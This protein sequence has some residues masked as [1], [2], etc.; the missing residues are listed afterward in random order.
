[1]RFSTE[2][3]LVGAVC[4]SSST[5][6]LCARRRRH[7]VYVLVV[8]DTMSMCSSTSNTYVRVTCKVGT[9]E[10]KLQHVKEENR[11]LRTRLEAMNSKYEKLQSHLQEISDAEKVC[12]KVNQSGSASYLDTHQRKRPEFS[13]AQKPSQIFVRTHPNDNSLTVKDGYQWKKYGQK[14]TKDNASPRA[15]FKCSMAP[16]CPVKKRVQR[17]IQDRSILVA[18]YEGNHNHGVFHDLLKPSSSTPKEAN[19]LPMTIM[20]NDKDIMNIDLALCDWA[21]TDIRLCENDCGNN[22]KIEECASSLIKDPDF[23]IP[24]AEAVVHS[25]NNENKQLGLNLNLGLPE[26]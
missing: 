23:T 12:T 25:T 15:Y 2:Q 11:T 20:P 13:Q 22:S 10:A 19:N 9:L 17:S 26:P 1:M 6:C 5:P 14:V 8:V 21:Q 18:T 7:H 4:S 16:S 24:S 3:C